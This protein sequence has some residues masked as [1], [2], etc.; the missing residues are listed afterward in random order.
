MKTDTPAT[1]SALLV[2]A[3]EAA[4]LC[5]VSRSTWW[6]LHSSGRVPLPV[7]LGG[8]TLWR[9]AELEEWVAAGC[10]ARVR[11]EEIGEGGR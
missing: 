10:P 11:W 1:M 5:G 3:A 7:R 6:A 2:G 8:R 9:R 4:A